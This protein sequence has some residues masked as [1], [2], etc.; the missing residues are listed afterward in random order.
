[1]NIDEVWVE[2]IKILP[3]SFI[4]GSNVK[5]EKFSNVKKLILK[6]LVSYLNVL[7]RGEFF[8][9]QFLIKFFLIMLF[10]PVFQL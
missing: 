3:L 2:S 4:F 5:L 9:G 10:S 1:M 8:F 7:A 6:A